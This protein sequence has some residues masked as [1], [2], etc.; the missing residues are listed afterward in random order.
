MTMDPA[1]LA[2]LTLHHVP[3][4][5]RGEADAPEGQWIL[6]HL[7]GAALPLLDLCAE[8]DAADVAYV[9][10]AAISATTLW[11]LSDPDLGPRA[12]RWLAELIDE[13]QRREDGSPDPAL[14]ALHR[15]QRDRVQ[16][17][18]RRL[19]IVE[20]AGGILSAYVDLHRRGR[21]ELVATAATHGLL[22]LTDRAQPQIEAGAQAIEAVFGVRPTGCWLPEGAVRPGLVDDLVAA[23]MHYV[24]LPAESLPGDGPVRLGRPGADLIALPAGGALTAAPVADLL[25]RYGLRVEGEWGAPLPPQVALDYARI[26]DPLDPDLPLWA[27]GEGGPLRPLYDPAAAEAAAAEHAARLLA[28]GAAGVAV[29]SADLLGQGWIEGPAFFRA[30]CRGLAAHGGLRP[31]PVS[32]LAVT[33]PDQ[34]PVI[35]AL[36]T[37]GPGGDLRWWCDEG[38][39]WILPRLHDLGARLD[40]CRRQAPAGQAAALL[41]QATDEWMLAAAS[42]WPALMSA[43]RWVEVAIR[44]VRDHLWACDRLCG[45]VESQLEDQEIQPSEAEITAF[46]EARR[47][48]WP[49]LTIPPGASAAP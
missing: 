48:Q 21:L 18:A 12:A 33:T 9:F 4:T 3:A 16:A 2:L 5:A 45:W 13:L 46:A 7:L 26:L 35:P 14:K 19:E 22:P 6:R 42:D 31:A 38:N 25:P 10:S 8:L 23:G 34:G 44:R 41:A 39:G 28:P 29:F 11:Q 37:R 36:A 30:L 47:A 43:G 20:A 32:A 24:V 15:W 1:P 27:S 17:L 40:A 49:Q